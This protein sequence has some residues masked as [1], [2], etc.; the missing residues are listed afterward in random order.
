MDRDI[1]F[2][3]Q[4]LIAHRGYHNIKKGIPE[5]SILAFEEAI[6]YNLTIE[7]DVHILTDGKVVV[8]H[9]DNIKRMT[10]I[11]QNIKDMDYD[12]IKKIQLQGTNQ[13][14]PLL[15]EVLSLVDGKV[16]II[17]EL[18]YDVKCG[19]LEKEVI[20]ILKNYNGKYAIKSF[21]P[22][23]IMYFKKEFSNVIRGLLV[24]DFKDEK[25][26]KLRKIVLSKMLFNSI[27]KPDFISYDIKALPNRRV[28]KLRRNKIILGWTIRNK[29][30]LEKAEK[31]CDNF[32]CEN[33]NFESINVYQNIKNN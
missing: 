16:P 26:S 29:E 22:F 31:Y 33:I 18:K 21:N 27:T 19:V 13:R 23:S 20:K 32:I 14:I 9:D 7:L 30:D 11:D 3:T 8:F 5:N 4:N 12:T 25:M 24:S 17:I 28:A 1:S 6:K 2:L 10:G 15:Q